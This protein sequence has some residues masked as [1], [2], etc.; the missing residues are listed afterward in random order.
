MN[1]FTFD[2]RSAKNDYT[3]A[4]TNTENMKFIENSLNNFAISK[5]LEND[6]DFQL[7]RDVLLDFMERVKDGIEIF[8]GNDTGVD[9]RVIAR[10]LYEN[11]GNPLLIF[12]LNNTKTVYATTRHTVSFDLVKMLKSMQKSELEDK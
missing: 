12:Q 7:M 8:N 4:R 5:G 11:D 1:Q 10:R 2:G 3:N 9:G 6:K